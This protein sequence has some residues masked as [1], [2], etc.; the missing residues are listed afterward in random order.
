[1]NRLSDLWP[2]DLG[3]QSLIAF[4]LGFV[5]VAAAAAI[6]AGVQSLGDSLCA[7]DACDDYVEAERAQGE[8]RGRYLAERNAREQAPPLGAEAARRDLD[9]LLRDGS[10]NAGYALAYHHA[11]NDAVNQLARRQP[12]QLLAEQDGTQW[13]ELLRTEAPQ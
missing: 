11:W 7:E 12:N 3:R 4:I 1:M 6:I 9:R 13:I 8:L 2:Y 5:A 10:P